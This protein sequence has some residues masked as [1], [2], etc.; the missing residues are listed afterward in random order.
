MRPRALLGCEMGHRDRHLTPRRLVL[1]ALPRWEES[2]ALYHEKP[3]FGWCLVRNFRV[4]PDRL[5]ARVIMIRSYGS[6]MPRRCAWTIGV[7]WPYLT[8]TTSSLHAAHVSWHLYFRPDW[9]QALNDALTSL[10]T[11]ASPT[12]RR[13]LLR[14]VFLELRGASHRGSNGQ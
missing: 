11:H 8:A 2:T 12:A 4:L 1:D 13:I 14:R 6:V 10:P 7:A 9:I 5:T 3:I